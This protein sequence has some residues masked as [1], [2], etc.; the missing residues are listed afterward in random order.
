MAGDFINLWTAAKLVLSDRVPDIYRVDQ[1]MA[2]QDT[3][4]GGADIGLR[5]WAYPPHSLLLVWPFGLFGFYAA[6]ALWS[7]IGLAVLVAGARRFG[8]D[9]LE[10]AIISRHQPLF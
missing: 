9:R 2:Y 1:F 6:L 7:L 5:L 3:F 10:I 8:F 4:T